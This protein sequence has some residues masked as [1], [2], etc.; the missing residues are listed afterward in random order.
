[1]KKEQIFRLL[2]RNKRDETFQYKTP[3]NVLKVIL[4]SY[5]GRK[6]KEIT[7]SIIEGLKHPIT[8]IFKPVKHF[9]KKHLYPPKRE[10]LETNKI[11]SHSDQSTNK[12]KPIEREWENPFLCDV[13][14]TK[15]PKTSITLEK[16]DGTI[17]DF[18]PED[19][20]PN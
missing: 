14:K 15:V 11:G 17:V 18:N 7:E 8:I 19:Y 4:Y 13:D 3:K 20:F 10:V 12:P 2:N 5:T 6:I 9:T 16:A 1:M